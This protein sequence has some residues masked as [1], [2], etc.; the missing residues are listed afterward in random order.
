MSNNNTVHNSKT[1]GKNPN[2]PWHDTEEE[3][4]SLGCVEIANMEYIKEE[5]LRTQKSLNCDGE[6]GQVQNLVYGEDTCKWDSVYTREIQTQ[7][8]CGRLTGGFS[9]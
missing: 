2:T 3:S 8:M 5:M 4:C 9:F 6:Q 1:Q 7:S